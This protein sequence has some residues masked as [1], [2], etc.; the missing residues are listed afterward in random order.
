MAE[1]LANSA[2]TTSKDKRP[3]SGSSEGAK[4]SSIDDMAEWERRLV[5]GDLPDDFLEVTEPQNETKVESEKPASGAATGLLVDI[6]TVTSSNTVPQEPPSS[7][8]PG[9]FYAKDSKKNQIIQNKF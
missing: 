6:P 4:D 8:D 2:D 7:T 3:N 5:E 1:S 9:N